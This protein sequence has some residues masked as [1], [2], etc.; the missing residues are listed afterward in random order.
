MAAGV[1]CGIQHGYSILSLLRCN[2]RSNPSSR[3]ASSRLTA[4]PACCWWGGRGRRGGGIC[5]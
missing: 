2:L 3:G 1:D 5:K 4:N